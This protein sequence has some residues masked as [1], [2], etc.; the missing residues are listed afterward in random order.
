MNRPDAD[1]VSGDGLAGRVLDELLA[2]RAA[3][4]R[5]TPQKL[6]GYPALVEVTGAND[7]LDA[8][9][10]FRREL[11]RYRTSANRDHAAAVLSISADFDTVLDRLQYTADE[12]SD[13]LA[14]Q[15]SARRWS[16]RGM[17]TIA[18]DLVYMAEVQQRLGQELLSV[19]LQGDESELMLVIEQMVSTELN[20]VAPEVKLWLT[21]DDG[22]PEELVV[23]LGRYPASTAQQ[24]EYTLHRHRVALAGE[25][26]AR[27]QPGQSLTV[28]ITGRNAPMRTAFF[29]DRATL[30][31]RF[32][33]TFSCYRTVVGVEVG[34]TTPPS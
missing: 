25:L 14:D 32:A 15:R 17:P 1:R 8:F 4:G 11:E 28:S 23:D 19:E 26:L 12:L 22:D 16:D 30:P 2:V 34:V 3:K 29:R 31:E 13:G 10:A 5:L 18:R 21:S 6:S 27:V 7:L 33:V 9:F 24:E 20:V